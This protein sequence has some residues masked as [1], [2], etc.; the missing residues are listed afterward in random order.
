MTTKIGLK[1]DF[2]QS[3]QE[4]LI[5]AYRTFQHALYFEIP[6]VLGETQRFVYDLESTIFNC[7]YIVYNEQI[8]KRIF[9]HEE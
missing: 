7:M 1:S 8:Q 9:N 3:V 5:Y 6:F 2:Q 4:L